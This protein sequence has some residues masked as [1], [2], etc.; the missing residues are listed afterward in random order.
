[1]EMKASIKVSSQKA[2]L[3]KAAFPKEPVSLGNTTEWLWCVTWEPRDKILEE[4]LKEENA[5]TLSLL[6]PYLLLRPLVCN[7]V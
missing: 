2:V 3:F 1:M 5:D 7:L 4:M 6:S